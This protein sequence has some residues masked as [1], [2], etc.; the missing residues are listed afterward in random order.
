MELHHRLRRDP[1]WH[2]NSCNI[3]GQLGHQAANC[4]NGTIDWQR[5]YGAHA[6]VMHAP[7]FQSDIDAAKKAKQIHFQE[8]E[9][10]ARDYAKMR[11]EAA[12]KQK[13]L[14]IAA[15]TAQEMVAEAGPVVTLPQAE[16]PLPPGWATAH[17]AQGKVYYWHTQSKKVQWDKPTLE[18]PI[19]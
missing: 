1:N 3:C 5:M 14:D 2:P 12:S 10:Q 9:Q 16:A 11:M 18:T 7:I 6:F 17:D 19:L 8:L 13:E 15:K 4:P